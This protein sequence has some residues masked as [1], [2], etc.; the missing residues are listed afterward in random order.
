MNPV[1][2]IVAFVAMTISLKAAAAA[3]LS[4]ETV[5][6][7]DALFANFDHP[8]APGASVMVIRDGKPIFAKGYGLANLDTK[9]PCTTNT[10]FRLASVSKQFTAMAVMIL[11]ERNALSFGESL[12]AFFPEFP[13]YG[14]AITVRHLL[15]HTSGLIAYEDVIPE[16]TTIPVLDQD[17]LRLL[18][19]QDKTYFPPGTQYRY[20]NSAYALLALIVEVRSGQTFARFLRENIFEPLKMTNT[21]AYEE[22]LAVVSNRAYG[23]T[24]KSNVWQRTDQSLT[25]AVLGDGGVYSSVTDL[26]KWDQALYKSKLVSE[27]MLRVAFS[28]LTPTDRPG[29]SYGF[30]WY[31]TEYRGM[32]EIYHSGETIGFRTRI[33]RYPEKNFTIIILANRSDTKVDD[34]PH[35]IADVILFAGKQ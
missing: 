32:K 3:G 34:F 12:T 28:P 15:T 7:V 9:T 22:G 16:G 31:I 27:P 8:N 2:I 20:S 5:A 13:E 26:A 10:N 17:V 25:S 14:K 11:A 18:M 35:Q 29:R 6:R 23:H 24:L 19:K 30:G 1:S 21:L 4:A 33:I